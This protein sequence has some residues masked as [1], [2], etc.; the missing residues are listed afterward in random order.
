MQLCPMIFSDAKACDLTCY[1]EN[2]A[3]WCPDC[4]MCAIKRLAI[5]DEVIQPIMK[6]PAYMDGSTSAL[7]YGS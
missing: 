2:C 6:S 1:K 5:K 7:K 3:W 4:Q